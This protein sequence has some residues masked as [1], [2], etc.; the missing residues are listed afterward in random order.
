[1]NSQAMQMYVLK[2]QHDFAMW[3]NN[4]QPK[5]RIE[6]YLKISRQN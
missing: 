6:N 4:A 2:T 5:V 1:M 3:D